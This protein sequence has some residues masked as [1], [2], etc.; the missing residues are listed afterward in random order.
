[1]IVVESAQNTIYNKLK[2]ER[3]GFTL[4][5]SKDTVTIHHKVNSG[6]LEFTLLPI[7][8]PTKRAHFL[9]NK[10]ILIKLYLNCF[11]CERNGERGAARVWPLS[12]LTYDVRGRINIEPRHTPTEIDIY[13]VY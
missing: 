7:T 8:I 1:M 13:D 3:I 10:S 11:E 5:P 4:L 12:E 6:K 9:R 2:T